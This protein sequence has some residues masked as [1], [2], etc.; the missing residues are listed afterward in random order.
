M[1]G[2]LTVAH[3]T[4]HEVKGRKVALAALILGAAFLVVFGVGFYF[5]HRDIITPARAQQSLGLSFLVMAGLYAANFLMV[6]MAVLMP[7]DT[8]AGDIR[9]GVIQTLVTKPLPRASIVLGKW[10]AFWVV[11]ALYLIMIAGG[12]MLIARV[13]AGYE[14][15]NAL[16]SLALMLLEGTLLMT[17]SILGGTRLSTLANGVMVFGLYG[18]AFIGSWLEQLGAALD[19]LTTQNIG[20]IASLIMPSESVWQLASYLMQPAL[21]RDL[22]ISPFSVASV[23]SAAMVGW[24]LAYTVGALLLALRQFGRRDL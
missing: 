5:A 24:A 7:V 23:P 1:M 11:L 6:M 3:L 19:N 8:L 12:V 2:I 9:S 16:A 13:I 20:I 4:L 21:M 17:L 14:V 15:Q 22:P 18:L 10:L